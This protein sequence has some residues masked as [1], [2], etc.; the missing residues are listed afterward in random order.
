MVVRRTATKLRHD[1]ENL[2]S[3]L[4]SNHNDESKE[5]NNCE[6]EASTSKSTKSIVSLRRSTRKRRSDPLDADSSEIN[7]KKSCVEEEDSSI[8]FNTLPLF[9]QKRIFGYLPMRDRIRL[10]T[11]SKLWLRL[12]RDSW[13]EVTRADIPTALADKLGNRNSSFHSFSLINTRSNFFSIVS[14][15]FVLLMIVTFA[16]SCGNAVVSCRDWTFSSSATVSEIT[17]CTVLASVVFPSKTSI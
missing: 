7:S 10:E 17:F 14:Q 12:L 13:A 11:V 2:H 8:S 3:N 15:D 16:V 6:M 5:K 4:N 9:I 1:H